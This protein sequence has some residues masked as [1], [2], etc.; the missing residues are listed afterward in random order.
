MGQQQ[1][2][3][4]VMDVLK[5]CSIPTH[6]VRAAP[7]GLRFWL[8]VDQRNNDSL[9][10]NCLDML[11]FMLSICYAL[12]NCPLHT[13][14]HLFHVFACIILGMRTP[15]D[16]I[17]VAR[18]S[19][20]RDAWPH[21]VAHAMP[22]STAD[23]SMTA[24]R[25]DK[26]IF[27]KIQWNISKKRISYYCRNCGIPQRSNHMLKYSNITHCTFPAKYANKSHINRSRIFLAYI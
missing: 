22:F 3:V 24:G 16:G 8:T 6:M 9:S 19:G 7:S 27:F 4:I 14:S 15:S 2:Y 1:Y 13:Y 12:F 10:L 26:I 18:Y 11:S 23:Y 5:W 25:R 17:G 20:N 21:N